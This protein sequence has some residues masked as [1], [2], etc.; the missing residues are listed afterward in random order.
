[1]CDTPECDGECDQ[2]QYDKRYPSDEIESTK[3]IGEKYFNRCR[4]DIKDNISEDKRRMAA[5]NFGKNWA[6]IMSGLGD[7]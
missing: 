7:Q 1:M 6:N 5:H 3:K 4:D 2:C